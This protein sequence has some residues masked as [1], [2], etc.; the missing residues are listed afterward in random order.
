MFLGDTPLFLILSVSF[1]Y[2]SPHPLDL[3]YD[4]SPSLSG[5]KVRILY[6][7]VQI[8]DHGR[9]TYFPNSKANRLK[10][11]P[12]GRGLRAINCRVRAAGHKVQ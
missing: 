9:L 11:G 3:P 6:V 5:G 4:I 8:S 7:I 1:D 10:C 12:A 2:D